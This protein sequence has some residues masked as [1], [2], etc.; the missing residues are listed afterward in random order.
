MARLA[1]LYEIWIL[2]LSV[3]SCHI[4][5]TEKYIVANFNPR[6]CVNFTSIGKKGKSTKML[7]EKNRYDPPKTASKHLSWQD[8]EDNA[9][10]SWRIRI[11]ICLESLL[12]PVF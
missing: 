4:D 10:S 6:P 3:Y 5:F 7:I 1:F 2:R 8:I 12:S 11:E 9:I